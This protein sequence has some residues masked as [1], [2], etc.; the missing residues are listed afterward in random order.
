MHSHAW[1][2][3]YIAYAQANH[4]QH[5]TTM[6]PTYRRVEPEAS[7]S[8]PYLNQRGRSTTLCFSGAGS[9]IGAC[10]C[11]AQHAR[12]LYSNNTHFSATRR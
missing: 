2:N 7:V 8:V 1:G 4:S 3:Y 5:R 12:A 6:I 10:M 9:E 11:H